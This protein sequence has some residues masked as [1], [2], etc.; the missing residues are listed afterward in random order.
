MADP[1]EPGSFRLGCAVWAYP[2]WN[3][4]FYPKAPGDT[5]ERYAERLTA[6][7][8]NSFFYA[9]PGTETLRGWVE[10]TPE[11]FR[12]C[13]KLP[14]DVTHSGTLA[15]SVELARRFLDYLEPLRPRL[16]PIFAQ[17]PPSYGPQRL[18]DLESFLSAW[19][20]G[21]PPLLVEVRHAGWYEPQPHAALKALTAGLGIGRVVL[22][23]RAVY[24]EGR[25]PQLATRN[26]K[27]K[28]P[29]VPLATARTCMVRFIGNPDPERNAGF[30]DE[31]ARKVDGWLRAGRD[32]YFFAHC[33]EEAHSPFIAR[34][35][36]ARLEEL[37]APAPPLPWDAV[38]GTPLQQDLF[39]AS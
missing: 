12:F 30:L 1:S 11:A 34:E 26:R 4:S 20:A 24:V 3:G 25:D 9:L 22:D 8:G 27:P 18:D 35:L 23:T 13:P 17:L 16:G 31:W 14:R 7:E 15:P 32:V 5:L 28:V 10:R 39:D 6:V 33:P 2:G 21:A 37:G 29:A 36:Q 38:P 19:P